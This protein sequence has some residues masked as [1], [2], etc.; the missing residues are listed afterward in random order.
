MIKWFA[1]H[2]TAANLLLVIIIAAG[3]FTAPSLIKETFPDYN[4]TEVS[5]DIKYKGA[6][7]SD[8]ELAI[9]SRVFDAVKSVDYLVD[10]Q[11]VSQDNF[12]NS[13]AKMSPQGDPLRFLNDLQTE[14]NAIKNL[15]RESEKPIIKE[16]HR[17]DLVMA[18]AITPNIEISSAELED[19]ALL[20]QKELLAL[21]GVAKVQLQGVS[22]RQWLIEADHSVL[23]KYGINAKNLA[24][25]IRGQNVDLPLG[26]LET[27][28]SN[29]SLRLVEQSQ[30]LQDLN[31]IVIKTDS[32]GTELKLE[33]IAVISEVNE[34]AEEKIIFNGKQS[35]ILEV[36]KSKNSD[37]LKVKESVTEL[38][39]QKHTNKAFNFNI[40]QDMT[41]IVEDRLKMLVSNGIAGFILV[42]LVMSIFYKPRL[43]VWA[44]LGLPVA[45]MGAFFFMSITGMSLNM[46]TLVG[47]LMAIGIVMDDAI[48]I[49]DNIVKKFEE[50]HSASQAAYY[51]TIEVI[52][53]V[54]SSFLTTASVFVP[55]AFLAGELGAVLEVLPVALIGALTASLI[56]A[57]LILPH[58]IKHSGLKKDKQTSK[59]YTAFNKKFESFRSWVGEQTDKS[60]NNRGLV[61]SLVATFFLISTGYILGGHINSEAMPDMDGDVLEARILMPAGTPLDKT[62][63]AV[64]KVLNA[65][66][67]VSQKESKNSNQELIQSYQERYNYNLSV[68]EQGTHVATIIVDLLTAENRSITLD[69]LTSQWKDEIGSL[70]NI[71][72][73][74]IQEPGF[75]PA[76][77]PIEI[78]I[79][80]HDLD[81]LKQ[82][83][84]SLNAELGKYAAVYNITDNLRQSNPQKVFTLT[85]GAYTTG[86]T[87]N[88]IAS[89]LRAGVLGDVVDNLRIGDNEIEVVVRQSIESRNSLDDLT[90]QTIT[91]PNGELA[92]LSTV[93][94]IK[95]AISWA[96]I[97]Q[98]NG[99]RSV[100]V[101]ANVDTRMST[102]QEIVK[103]LE[104]TWF[105]GFKDEYPKL[106]YSVKGQVERSQETGGSIGSRL[107]IGLVGVFVILSFQF[108]SY[109]EPIVVFVTIPLA[110]L[111]ALWGH[112]LMGY[113]ISMP[114]LIGAASLSGIVVN[115]SILLI[116]FT[117]SNFE[118]VGDIKIAAGMA[119][120]ERLRPI[121]ISSTTT[122]IGLLPLLFESSTQAVSIKPLVISVVFGLLFSVVLVIV[123]IPAF[124][125][126][127]FDLKKKFTQQTTSEAV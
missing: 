118:K 66:Q 3:F 4:P 5:I 57:F 21:S 56:E 49:T 95:D 82:A 27:K 39:K 1:E 88:E 93:V 11:C 97:T 90:V 99:V 6:S 19:F 89:Q 32:N 105:K 123:V 103:S 68:N 47:L 50:S 23:S 106:S 67:A 120:R 2:P 70:D 114:S 55:L 48:V 69:E 35:V 94:N 17:T 108:K 51:G 111:G 63:D 37:A 13:I 12:A 109:L 104:S 117:K 91:L 72:Q 42:V 36:S 31:S 58:H 87:A 80:G 78:D 33:D 20:F 45:F 116:Q 112:V 65:L 46:I 76:G 125:T 38:L 107:L 14:I 77:I 124:Y 59:F 15:P 71:S 102:G 121:V 22:Q 9:C 98:T 26:T 110:L 84:N 113:Y 7:S 61:L 96:Q 126:L 60:I 53:G 44:V 25:I 30:S 43:A 16:L 40:T 86:L 24:A 62:E 92:P 81:T 100:T 85:E 8:V 101:S 119:S 73:L 29:I 34:K 83:A 115:N 127:L 52:P 74:I 79:L 64:T 75:G 28:H 10:F 18:I 122:I 41:S 54:L